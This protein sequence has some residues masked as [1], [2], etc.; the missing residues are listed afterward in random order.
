MSARRWAADLRYSARHPAARSGLCA[1]AAAA[2]L[3][4]AAAGAWWPAQREQAALEESIAAKRRSVVQ[5]RQADELARAYAQARGA[6]AVLEKKLQHGAT[7]AQLVENFARLAR[8]HGVRILAE[9]YDE[10]RGTAGAQ[11]ALSAELTVQGSYPALREFL[12]E[13]S[14]LPTWSEVHEVRLETVQGSGTQKGRIRIVT[15]RR[16]APAE[17]RRS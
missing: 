1:V 5:A 3:A 17:A 6:V 8:R 2:V 10:G 9:T 16:A 14:G 4:L 15:Y 12:R 7:Q 11:P 13:L